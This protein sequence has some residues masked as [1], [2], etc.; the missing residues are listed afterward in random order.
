MPRTDWPR[1]RPRYGLAGLLVGLTIACVVTMCL[2][3]YLESRPT[4]WVDYTPER[5]A[6]QRE[7]RTILVSFQADWS[8]TTAIN[9]KM[10]ERPAVA[11]WLRRHRVVAMRAD[12]TT[13]S[14]Q[15]ATALK[16]LNRVS[17]PVIAIYRPEGAGAPTVIDGVISDNQILNAL[18]STRD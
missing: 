2:K 7:N 4:E 18:Q 9:Q 14:P 15:V 17:V 12:F 16:N 1:L 6:R 13:S 8:I 10:I 3:Y 11:R 5:F